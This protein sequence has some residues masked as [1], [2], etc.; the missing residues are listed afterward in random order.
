MGKTEVER[1]R[2]SQNGEEKVLGIRIKGTA[3]F[4]CCKYKN[5]MTQRG[6]CRI[7]IDDWMPNR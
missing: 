1:K 7:P 2:A 3:P 5:Q 6:R 4:A